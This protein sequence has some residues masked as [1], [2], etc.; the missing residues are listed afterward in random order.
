VAAVPVFAVVFWARTIRD[1]FLLR[2]G[3][4]AEANL[5]ARVEMAKLIASLPAG[6]MLPAGELPEGVS[7]LQVESPYDDTDDPELASYNAHLAKLNAKERRKA[8][9]AR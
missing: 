4:L 8:L 5:V 9:G 2:H 6:A 7:L 3:H 1:E